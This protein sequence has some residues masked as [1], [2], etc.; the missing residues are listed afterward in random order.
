[1]TAFLC[2]VSWWVLATVSGIVAGVVRD[3]A[4]GG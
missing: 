3:R 2:L 4:L 1:V